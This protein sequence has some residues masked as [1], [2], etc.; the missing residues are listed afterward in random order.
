MVLTVGL[1]PTSSP[2]GLEVGDFNGDG[3][4]D[5]AWGHSRP[6]LPS[7]EG[8]KID[9][10]P[11][12]AL[13]KSGNYNDVV[14]WRF[15]NGTLSAFGD[16]NGGGRSDL[17][18]FVNSGSVRNCVVFGQEASTG[19]WDLT[20][21][22]IDVQSL[23]PL[24]GPLS[25]SALSGDLTGDGIADLVATYS[26]ESSAG[27]VSNG[28]V[29]ILPGRSDWP[30]SLIWTADP[31]SKTVYGAANGDSLGISSWWPGVLEG[32]IDNDGKSDLAINSASGI[33]I[34]FGS[35]TL[36]KEWDLATRPANC[37][38][39]PSGNAGPRARTF[40]DIN[41]DGKSDMILERSNTLYVLDGTL[42]I[43]HPIID[44]TPGSPTEQPLI[45][46]ESTDASTKIHCADFD[47]DGRSDIVAFR[48]PG[49]IS[50]YLTSAVSAWPVFPSAMNEPSLRFTSGKILIAPA[51]GDFNN[52]GHDDLVFGEQW[53]SI[54]A[55]YGY[56]PL[57]R[58]SITA[59]S[60]TV[61][62]ARATVTLSVDGDPTEMRFSGNLADSFIDQW[63]PYA[64]AKTVTL[65]PSAG[66]K[67]LSVR[68]RN[69][70]ERESETATTSVTLQIQDHRAEVINNLVTKEHPAR[71]DCL[72]KEPG[73]LKASVFSR[74][75]QKVVDLVDEEKGIGDWPVEW[76]GTNS[77]GRR[78]AP[79]V[80]VL[81]TESG[82]QETRTKV[83]VRE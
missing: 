74:L 64:T 23:L 10:L 9:I 31:S 36:P 18:S 63:I 76:D 33:Y 46:I 6:F 58:P 66:D 57:T 21:P 60:S 17:V 1:G 13:P 79:G 77:D 28:V 48:S 4:D 54:Y 78:V 51:V 81:W 19:T 49:S 3:F 37:W 40:G 35:S 26:T 42:I 16:Y 8:S 61:Q 52:D 43:T 56:R 68:F 15:L 24:D 47:G 25:L 82:G 44:L 83:L 75:G 62:T 5:V 70:F 55:V 73:Q 30:N 53:G 71:I 72:M 34:I 27:R 65:S 41:G 14:R 80:Y 45:P 39:G 20:R 11:G 29:R 22:D 32:D 12:G 2:Y 59:E 38:I 7:T 67:I 50:L 69:A